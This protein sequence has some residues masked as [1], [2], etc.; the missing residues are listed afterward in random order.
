MFTPMGAKTKKETIAD[1]FKT[2]PVQKVWL[3]DSFSCG[4]ETLLSE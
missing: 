3:F 1:Y 2:Q 4:E